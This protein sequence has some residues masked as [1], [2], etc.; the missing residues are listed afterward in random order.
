M[1]RRFLAWVRGSAPSREEVLEA[2]ARDALGG[3]GSGGD[4][5]AIW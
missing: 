3:Y 4:P 1:L 5:W 2:W